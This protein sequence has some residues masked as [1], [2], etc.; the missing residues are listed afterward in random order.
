MISNLSI[1]IH[2]YSANI[3]C[4][5][6]VVHLVLGVLSVFFAICALFAGEC[7]E[8][9]MLASG[10]W[11]GFIYAGAGILGVLASKRWYV[12]RQI[13]IFLLA[14]TVT[15]VSSIACIAITTMGILIETTK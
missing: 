12:R 7:Y 1:Y 4:G 6:G 5:L 14:A 10:L 13:F 15:L 9:N 11:A 8:A 3:V 2:R